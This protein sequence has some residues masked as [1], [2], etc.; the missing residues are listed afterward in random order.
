MAD[1]GRCQGSVAVFVRDDDGV[2]AEVVD[3][4]KSG[5]DGRC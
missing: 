4:Q 5:L 2:S 1:D 3:H